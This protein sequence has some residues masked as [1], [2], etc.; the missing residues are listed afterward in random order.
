MA[1]CAVALL[2][3]GGAEV[4]AGVLG[5]GL[6]VMLAL[7]AVALVIVALVLGAKRERERT[8]ALRALAA[9]LGMR[10][11]DRDPSLDARMAAF[12]MFALGHSRCGLNLMEGNLVSGGV[13]MSVLCGDYQYKVTTSNGKQTTTTTYNL[14]FI[15]CM[16]VLSIGEDL[17]IREEG[18][19]DKLGAFMGFD[20]IDFE[21]S[22]FS[23]RFHVKCS[24]RRFAFDLFDP[25]MMEYFLGS[26]APRIHA[27]SGVLL[28]D[29]GT[30]RWD[31]AEFSGAF[32]WI[33]GFFARVPR[34]VRAARLPEADRAADPVLNPVHADGT[35][36]TGQA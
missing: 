17:T 12:P 24:D 9:G 1:A 3:Q 26:R 13:R 27:R 34:H 8:E 15:A 11:T 25:R 30:K 21:S 2:A 4:A 22:E 35:G 19:F 14:S 29:Y 5:G 31:P 10:F 6:V 32:R 36:M 23:K 33:D 18:L 28:F 20:D 16:P 7:G